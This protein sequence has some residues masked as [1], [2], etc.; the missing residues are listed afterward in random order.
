MLVVLSLIGI[1]IALVI[2]YVYIMALLRRVVPPNYIDVVVDVKGV[3]LFSS[4]TDY[5]PSGETVYHEFP[6]WVPYIGKTVTRIPLEIITIP[7][8]DLTLFDNS[9]ARFDCD[10]YAYVIVDEPLK[11]A[12]RMPGSISEMENQ[13]VHI[14]QSSARG[15][16]TT[17]TLQEIITNRTEL[18]DALREQIA[19]I[20]TNWGLKLNNVE[21]LRFKDSPDTKSVTNLALQ[22]E[23]EIEASTR[24]QIATR[25]KEAVLT[26]A[27]AQ[28]DAEK[29]VIA[30]EKAIDIANQ[31][32]EKAIY[33]KE[34]EATEKKFEVEKV[35]LVKHEENVKEAKKL[36]GEGELAYA[37]GNVE[38][39]VLPTMREGEVDAEVTKVKGEADAVVTQKVGT[40]KAD[41]H[42]LKLVAEAEGKEKIKD[43]V[44]AIS[45]DGLKAMVMEQEIEKDRQVDIETAKALSNADIRVLAGGGD[46]GGYDL[47][48]L[49]QSIKVGDEQGAKAVLNRLARPNDL[50]FSSIDE[51]FDAIKNNP[52]TINKIK[53]A[54]KQNGGKEE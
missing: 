41:V 23:K 31:E 22:R 14:L 36:A 27:A 5:N 45:E 33:E 17:K 46:S 15:T 19:V 10:L 20:V 13:I 12:T 8:N 29:R 26:E 52:K 24:Q 54:I 18:V 4:N 28:E 39:N 40:A 32:K 16:S 37:K 11:A 25:E 1:I 53:K 50:G 48:R 9:R 6:Q 43:V 2:F 35:E 30:M 44:N 49:L 3:K 38:A 21:L 7:V 42:K 34:K 51:M 47:A